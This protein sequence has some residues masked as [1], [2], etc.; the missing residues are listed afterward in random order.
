MTLS[1]AGTQETQ[2]LLTH[3]L[4][5]PNGQKDHSSFYSLCGRFPCNL[6][7]FNSIHILWNDAYEYFCNWYVSINKKNILFLLCFADGSHWPTALWPRVHPLARL[8]VRV[9]F[10]QPALDKQH[11]GGSR[12]VPRLLVRPS[13]WLCLRVV[14]SS[15]PGSPHSRPKACNTGGILMQFTMEVVDLESR[16]VAKN[17]LHPLS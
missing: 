5:R 12:G 6:N 9:Q 11:P 10:R 15:A 4:G 17:G 2:L 7:S 1:L 3:Q 8:H 16:V 14:S 13:G